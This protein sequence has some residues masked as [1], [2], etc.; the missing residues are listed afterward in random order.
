MDEEP[1]LRA[2]Q[3]DLDAFQ[4]HFSHI[5]TSEDVTQD[6]Q[7]LCGMV[8]VWIITYGPTCEAQLRVIAQLD[9]FQEEP[10]LLDPYLS[11]IVA[12]VMSHLC[13]VLSSPAPKPQQQVDAYTQLAYTVVKVRGYKTIGTFLL[14]SPPSRSE[15]LSAKRISHAVKL[16]PHA[17]SDLNLLLHWLDSDTNPANIHNNWMLRYILLLWLSLV[18]R[19][20]F[21]LKLWDQSGPSSSSSSSSSASHSS[22]PERILNMALRYTSSP[23]KD[24]D[25][26]SVLIGELCSR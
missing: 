19:L 13:A 9:A 26:A 24:R 11:G 23:G 5:Q 16:F 8:S 7:K 10:Y 18:V 25:A 3:F 17:P 14:A 6:V 20:P 2:N 1:N 15:G 12:A 22:T 4:K 21:N